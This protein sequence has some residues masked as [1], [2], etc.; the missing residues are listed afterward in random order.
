VTP[1]DVASLLSFLTNAFPS[2][3]PPEGTLTAW[4]VALEY[5]DRDAVQRAAVEHVRTAKW[6]PA[7]AEL[8]KPPTLD[9]ADPPPYCA[10]LPAE[11]P[12]SPEDFRRIL[13]PLVQ[14]MKAGLVRRA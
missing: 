7:V 9:R 8:L 3:A 11:S 2:W 12:A 10:A 1:R 4:S 13:G 5:A 6:P 14:R